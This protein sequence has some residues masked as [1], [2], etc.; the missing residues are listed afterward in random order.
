MSEFWGA[1]Y[2]ANPWT[3]GVGRWM[4]EEEAASDESASDPEDL[5]TPLTTAT[6]H[7]SSTK[8]APTPGV[9]GQPQTTVVRRSPSA[10][11]KVVRS[12]RLERLHEGRGD[13]VRASRSSCATPS[14][15]HIVVQN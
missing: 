12:R 5:R 7:A 4:S 8:R 1:K 11:L 6:Q 10:D 3:V 15:A 2:R 13:C 14:F 9:R